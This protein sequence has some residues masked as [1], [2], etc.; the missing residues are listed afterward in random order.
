[1]I[2]QVPKPTNR[3]GVEFEFDLIDDAM[4]VMG[5]KL[6]MNTMNAARQ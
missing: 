6:M 1:V 3:S 4:V 2:A 5:M